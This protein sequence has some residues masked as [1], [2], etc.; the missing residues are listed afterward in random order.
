[1][2][3]GVPPAVNRSDVVE[4]VTAAFAAYEHAL[5]ANDIPVLIG[6][7]WDSPLTVRFGI[8]EIHYGHQAIAEFRRSQAV[9]TLPRQLRNVVVTTFGVDLA[10]VDAEFV[11]EGHSVVGRQ[12]Q[13]WL[14]T[15]D[16]WRVASAHVSWLGGRAPS[17]PRPRD[18]NRD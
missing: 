17:E 2:T 6:F 11:P 16:G 9:A 18:L 1:M 14:R 7:F 3:G 8:D 10:T 15:D 4:E 12:S 5:L 13:T